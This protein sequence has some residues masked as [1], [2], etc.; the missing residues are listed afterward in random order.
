MS[1]KTDENA[2][3]RLSILQHTYADTSAYVSIRQQFYV[4]HTYADVCQ[5]TQERTRT[6]ARAHTYTHTIREFAR[7]NK[8]PCDHC[9]NASKAV[10]SAYVSIRQHPS[11]YVSIRQHTSEYVSKQLK[12]IMW[13]QA[14]V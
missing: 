8:G 10:L 3:A 2:L 7:R 13:I 9:P 12:S 4:L 1:A 6:R 11:A 14:W 5:N